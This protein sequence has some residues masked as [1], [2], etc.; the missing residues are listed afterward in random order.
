M[1]IKKLGKGIIGMVLIW[2]LYYIVWIGFYK[3]LYIRGIDFDFSR[4]LPSWVYYFTF[5]IATVMTIWVGVILIPEY[6]FQYLEER[7]LKRELR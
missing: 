3:I 7:N 1:K 2:S 5:L 4:I 6:V